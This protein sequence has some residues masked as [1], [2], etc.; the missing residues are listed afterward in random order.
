MKF[1]T[2]LCFAG[3]AL[4]SAASELR[5]LS[6]I[7]DLDLETCG[8]S[9]QRDLDLILHDT[10]R[11]CDDCNDKFK[12]VLGR[13]RNENGDGWQRSEPNEKQWRNIAQNAWTFFGVEDI[14]AGGVDR[15]QFE[16]AQI[17]FEDAHKLLSDDI[18]DDDDEMEDEEMEDDDGRTPARTLCS[19]NGYEYKPFGRQADDNS[20]A[21][22]TMLGRSSYLLLCLD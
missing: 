20:P 13:K 9:R 14:I 21:V 11:L 1:V 6:D 18:D 10:L 19:G 17:D 8:G 2:S 22:L 7:F 15:K 5:D 12:R 4:R 16:Q 3:L